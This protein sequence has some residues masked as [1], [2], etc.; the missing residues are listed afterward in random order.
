[1][2][3]R[4][5]KAEALSQSPEG[6]KWYSHFVLGDLTVSKVQKS[7][8]PEGS[9]WYSHPRGLGAGED[10]ASGTEK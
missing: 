3:Q 1:M 9:K 6:S 2:E 5:K 7:Q 4:A 8:S 10:A